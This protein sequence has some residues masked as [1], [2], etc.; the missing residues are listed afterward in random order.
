ME[1]TNI[2]IPTDFTLSSL[3]AVT[4]LLKK[5]PEKRFNITLVHFFKLSDSESELLMLARRNREYMH[6]T[7]EFEDQLNAIRSNFS[8]Q[9]GRVYPEFFYGNTVAIFKHFLEARGIETIVTLNGHTYKQLTKNS[10]DPQLL[11]KRSGCQLIDIVHAPARP[12]IDEDVI[13]ITRPQLEVQ[14]L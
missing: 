8:Q 9:I 3:N 6:I 13:A 1:T 14:I 12:Q 7:A 2:L 5:H 11:V 10:I 4:G